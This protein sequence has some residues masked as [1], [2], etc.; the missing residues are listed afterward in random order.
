[1]NDNS[2]QSLLEKIERWDHKIFLQ[3]YH[4]ETAKKIRPIA[5]VYSFFGNALFWAIIGVS[6]FFLNKMRGDYFLFFLFLG[7]YCQSIVFFLI[8]RYGF[9]NRSRPYRKLEEH[10]VNKD[11]D[12]IRE[13]RSFPS[14]HT[15]FFLFYGLLLSFYFASYLLLVLFLILT[16]LMAMSR[17]VLGMHFPSD[18]IAGLISGSLFALIYLGFTYPVWIDV[19]TFLTNLFPSIFY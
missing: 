18:V 16:V 15:A 4:N 12:F 5:Y 19:F 10:G 1:M 13:S 17:L 6:I 14:G 3:I 9:I 7:G 2:P 11:D 8:L